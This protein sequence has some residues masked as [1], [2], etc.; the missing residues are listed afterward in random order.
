MKF[1]LDTHILLWW[2]LDPSKLKKEAEQILT[3]SNSEIYIS[4]AIIWEMLIKSAVDKLK[5]PKGFFEEAERDFEILPIKRK[6]IF[7]TTELE[8]IHRDPF[9]RL[10]IAQALVEDMKIITRDREIL[11]YKI[12]SLEG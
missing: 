4:D 11:K 1:L 2:Y 3:N 10:L 7:K 12:E 6:H 5:I 9:D 8:L